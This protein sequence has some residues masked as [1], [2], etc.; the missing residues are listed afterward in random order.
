MMID[1]RQMDDV[2]MPT[3]E[4][5]RLRNRGPLT[6]DGTIR[7]CMNRSSVD[8]NSNDVAIVEVKSSYIRMI[9]YIS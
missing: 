7:D 2:C 6:K 8:E 4:I 5:M 9:R 3:S 1:G